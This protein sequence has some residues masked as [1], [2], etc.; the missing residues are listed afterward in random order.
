MAARSKTR[1]EMTT[2]FL[3]CW[4]PPR[5][6][7]QNPR[8]ITKNGKFSPY[9]ENNRKELKLGENVD[10]F[11]RHRLKIKQRSTYAKHEITKV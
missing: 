11:H 7:K 1:S 4:K 8:K 3:L 6:K 5:K 10:F 9:N 2:I